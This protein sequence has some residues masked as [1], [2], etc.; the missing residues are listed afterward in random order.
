MPMNVKKALEE[1]EA[2]AQKL[3]VT[4]N[5]QRFAGEGMSSGGICKVKGKWRVI[6]NS[7]NSD[8]DR[9]VVL[10]K[11]LGRFDLE[12]HFLSPAVR[13]LVESQRPVKEE[14]AE[15]EAGASSEP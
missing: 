13:E 1:L 7:K 5:Y 3:D 4:V 6:I 15:E 8:N 10:A 12:G 14:E 9:V 2:L 11:A